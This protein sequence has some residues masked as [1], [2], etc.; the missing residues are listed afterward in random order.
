LAIEADATSTVLA[1]TVDGAPAGQ[2][3][4]LVV[5]DPRVLLVGTSDAVFAA[6]DLYNEVDVVIS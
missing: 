3:Y 2:D 6:T 5:A 1:Y 4:V